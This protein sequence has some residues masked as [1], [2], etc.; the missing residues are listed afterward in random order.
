MFENDRRRTAGKAVYSIRHRNDIEKST[1]KTHP[2]LVD[3]ESTLK[4]PRR[5]DVI[6]ST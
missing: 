6:T 1:L 4:F 3:F 5:I 2:Y